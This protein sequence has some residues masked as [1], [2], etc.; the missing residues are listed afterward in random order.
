M[1]VDDLVFADGTTQWR[2]PGGN[3]VYAAL[4]MAVWGE[5]PGLLAVYGPDYPVEALCGRVD[6]TPS[7]THR[8]T[9]RNWGLYEDDGSR[10]F[11]FRRDTRNW[12]EFCP[13]A[14]DLGVEPIGACH[15]APL[16]W[17]RQAGM[18]VAA[19][20]RGAGPI[21]VDPDD[22]YITELSSTDLISLL[23]AVDAFLPSRQDAEGLFP[24]VCPRDA[25]RRLRALSPNT[26]VIG[27]KLGSEGVII[28][29]AG[30][31]EFLTLPSAAANVVDATGAGD[32]FCGGFLVGYARTGNAATAALMGS[33][34]AS[35]AVE[36][37]GTSGLSSAA[38]AQAEARVAALSAYVSYQP[39]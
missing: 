15:I 22:R 23:R 30:A 35:F 10:T 32:A 27:I 2:T 8:A 21:T 37:F 13:E 26:G 29:P 9:L 17:A 3:S 38:Q 39:L 34:S 1:S 14:S 18:V 31:R 33:V 7:R 28:H 36:G 19:R 6:L 12:L 20:D 25:L 5:R 11:L 4:G 16:P 24:G